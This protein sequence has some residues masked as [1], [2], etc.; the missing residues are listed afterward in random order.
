MKPIKLIDYDTMDKDFNIYKKDCFDLP[1]LQDEFISKLYNDV[2]L[3]KEKVLKERLSLL[4]IELNFESE[5][6]RRFKSLHSEQR[7]NE[8]I[9]YYNDG[10]ENGLRVVTFKEVQTPISFTNNTKDF[11]CSIEIDL[12]YY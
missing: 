3:S 7:G 5:Q 2:N 12:T 6:R 11:K 1:N 10:S 9:I 4:G 8:T